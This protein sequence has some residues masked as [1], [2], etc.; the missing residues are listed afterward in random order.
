MWFTAVLGLFGKIGPALTGIDFS[1]VGNVLKNIGA[2]ML[3]YWYLWI[4]GVLL[5]LNLFTGYEL[6]HTRDNLTKEVAAHAKDIQDFKTAQDTAN[7]NALAAQATLEKES[8]AS[9][10]QADSDYSS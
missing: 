3:K 2:S 9:A 5:A 7:A 6:K 8:K 10:D 1:A 4:I